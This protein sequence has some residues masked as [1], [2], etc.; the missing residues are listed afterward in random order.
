MRSE[1]N[2]N[3]AGFKGHSTGGCIT[4]VAAQ[5]S[6]LTHPFIAVLKPQRFS[7]LSSLSTS[8]FLRVRPW[9]VL[10]H[11]ISA[12]RQNRS[13]LLGSRSLPDSRRTCRRLKTK[14]TYQATAR[15]G[16]NGHFVHA[17]VKNHPRQDTCL[18]RVAR[19]G[20]WIPGK[21]PLLMAVGPLCYQQVL[22]VYVAPPGAGG[23]VLKTSFTASLHRF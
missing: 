11:V 16:H 8:Y 14:P 21:D 9:L 3:K 10:R 13:D 19:R 17:E 15:P 18:S 6:L 20:L 2:E 23:C 12:L 1:G 7:A 5:P 22:V 4:P